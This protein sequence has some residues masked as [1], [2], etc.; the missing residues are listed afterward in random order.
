MDLDRGPIS[1]YDRIVESID[2]GSP[3]AVAVILSTDG[4]TPRDA[5]VR[6]VI[7]GAGRIR[8]TLGGGSVEAAAQRWAVEACRSGLPLVV[9][10]DLHGSDSAADMP[11]CGG[12]VRLL[13][14]PTAA[15]DRA[16]FDQAARAVRE[17]RRGAVLTTVRRGPR[18][19]VHSRWL[20]Q[21][22]S[23]QV[24]DLPG[25]DSICSCLS[26][27][28]PALFPVPCQDSGVQV[29][30]LVEP[31][32]P[33][34]L[35]L[36]AG[37]GHVGQAVAEQASLV[38]FE[39]TVVD[40]RPEFTDSALFPPAVSACCGSIPD[41]I[42]ALAA[43]AGDAYIVIVTRGHKLDAVTLRACIRQPSA[44]IGMIGSRRKVALVRQEL[45]E[46]GEATD[47]ELARVFA[48]IGLGIGAVT[49]PEIATSIVA[50]LIAVRRQGSALRA[51][52]KTDLP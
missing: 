37:G 38:G 48:P 30:V 29:E 8:G 23:P 20:P 17:R 4:S 22:A 39:V 25:A 49:V 44:Y 16:C 5:G 18:T 46:A 7:D 45:T 35:L 10:L 43:E 13:V 19:E 36:I 9:D 51:S 24:L 47:A 40:D 31:V 2:G 34:P 12:A 33:R 1:I 11:I 41:R 27:E 50:E 6:A 32:V 21:E 14:D 3:F 42:A 15:K 52:K 28:A 26:R